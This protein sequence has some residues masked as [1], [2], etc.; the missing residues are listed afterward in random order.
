MKMVCFSANMFWAVYVLNLIKLPKSGLRRENCTHW[1]MNHSETFRHCNP[2]IFWLSNKR[3][4]CTIFLN[5]LTDGLYSFLKASSLIHDLGRLPFQTSFIL[6]IDDTFLWNSYSN[7]ETFINTYTYYL[8]IMHFKAFPKVWLSSWK[9][10][11]RQVRPDSSS[12]GSWNIIMTK[13][14]NLEHNYNEVLNMP[15]V[16]FILLL[17]D[18]KYKTSS[19]TNKW[20]VK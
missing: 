6:L 4:M 1:C 3:N 2:C 13:N 14:I 11:V 20:P 15:H 9:T 17:K 8:L 19:L 16:Y 10:Y 12:P 7:L 18:I 5:N